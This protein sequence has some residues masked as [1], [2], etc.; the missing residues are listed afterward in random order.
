[1]GTDEASVVERAGQPVA[2]VPGSPVNLKIT[3][4]GDLELAEFYLHQRAR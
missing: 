1:M 4:P 3:Q 2:V